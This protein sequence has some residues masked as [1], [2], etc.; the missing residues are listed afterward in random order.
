MA[1]KSLRRR[2]LDGVFWLTGVKIVG[3]VVSWTITIYVIRILSPNDYGLVAMAGVYI[4]FVTLFSEI[5]LS[6]AIVQKKDISQQDLSNIG[7]AVL[8]LNLALY[9]FSYL[10]APFVADFYNEPRVSDVIRIAS[11]ILIFRS[12]GLIPSNMLVREL[13]FDKQSQAELAA[14]T[15][16]G[17]TT[18]AL[19]L[20]GF[21]VWS[22]VFG[23]LTMEIVR[24][25]LCYLFFPWK[26]ELSFSF[27]QVRGMMQFGAKAALGRFMWYLSANM[28]L[29]IA[30]KLLG[31]TQLGYY[32]IAVQLA[33]MPLDKL[34]GST[35]SQVAFPA[36]SRTQDDLT[37]LRRYYL[38][39][40]NVV[41]F[42][43]FPVF[44]GI[45]LVA[46]SAVPL[47]LSEKWLP[48]V[49]PL[50]ILSMV[51]AFRAIHLVNA[52]LEM[53]VG[54]PGVSI[55]NF[56][57]II[58]V[59]ALS[60]LAGASFGL[61]GLA[62]AWL[63]FPVVFLVTTS[64]TL[65]LIGLPLGVYLKELKHPF[66][67]TGF[68]VALVFLMQELLLD[69]MGFVAHVAGTVVLGVAAYVL[70]YATFNRAMFTEARKLLRR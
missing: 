38:K 68:M 56:G 51:T 13:M 64:I 27:A 35:I 47:F 24:T 46:E 53:A 31:K 48:V 28:D 14:N 57:I 18:L 55:L 69:D 70:Y 65:R 37:V 29:L 67:G 4:S 8:A 2:V 62:Y 61:I 10:A 3:Q 40:V 17:I 12:I 20:Q 58:S 66:L 11:S 16:G 32:A 33:L 25:S 30:G 15:T 7:W 21:G 6:A 43:S 52:P 23:T 19:A 50:Q 34:M 49:L 1:E 63:S 39:I 54:R 22:L 41:A 45:F 26:P 42:V 9:A 59:L 5:G 36:F 44:W 60:F